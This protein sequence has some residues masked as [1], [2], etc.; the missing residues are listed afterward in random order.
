MTMSSSASAIE[1]TRKLVDPYNIGRVIA[2]TL[3]VL[4]TEEEMGTESDIA[5]IL[6]HVGEELAEKRVVK[7][8]DVL[9]VA[10]DH[11]GLFRVPSSECVKHV[12]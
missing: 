3:N 2:D 7:R 5:R 10:P 11:K 1:L 9:I 6:H 12:L 4:C 8:V